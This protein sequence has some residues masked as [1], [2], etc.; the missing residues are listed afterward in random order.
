MTK[1]IQ[2]LE[3]SEECNA[4]ERLRQAVSAC[5]ALT[6][7]DFLIE[8]G[9]YISKAKYKDLHRAAY[10]AMQGF[11]DYKG[12]AEQQNYNLHNVIQY[13]NKKSDIRALLAEI[14][15]IVFR[16]LQYSDP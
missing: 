1:C 8:H 16:I 4:R 5:T 3:N 2:L 9:Y 6:V 10:G 11:E 12:L 15:V 7:L 13:L 14:L